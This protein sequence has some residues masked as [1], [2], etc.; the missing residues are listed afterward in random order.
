MIYIYNVQIQIIYSMARVKTLNVV[1]ISDRI[2]V[3]LRSDGETR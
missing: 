3:K 1:V 2:T